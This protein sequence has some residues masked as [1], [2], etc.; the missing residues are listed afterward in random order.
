MKG[1][2][3]KVFIVTGGGSGIGAATVLRLLSEGARVVAAGTR[4]EGLERTRA[5]AGTAAAN[6]LAV[7]FN[8]GDEASIVSLVRQATERFGRLDGVANV[9]AMIGSLE[10]AERD[11][12]VGALDAD[13]WAE[14]MR[15]N[16]T[17]TGTV[18]RECLPALVAAGGGAIVNVSSASAWLGSPADAAYA[19]SKIALHTLTR[20]TA[21][22]WG[23]QNVRCNAVAPGLVLT[24]KGRALVP[25]D[26]REGMLQTVALPRHGQP[27]DLAATLTFLLSAD[28]S[29]ITGQILSVD[30]GLTMRE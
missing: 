27:E 3:D 19:S 9:A 20:H 7:Q 15:I 12:G 26:A 30:G 6:L 2:K 4:T 10:T 29:W 18:I 28:A 13:L 14:M 8:L 5:D 1:L 24:E 22:A 21:R 23:K 16:V 11:Q 17:G 25:E